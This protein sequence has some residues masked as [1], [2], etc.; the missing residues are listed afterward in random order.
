MTVQFL[1]RG[2]TILLTNLKAPLALLVLGSGYSNLAKAATD[3]TGVISSIE[4]KNNDPEKKS[5]GW[6]LGQAGLFVNLEMSNGTIQL[7]VCGFN[8]GASGYSFT[9]D[10]CRYMQANLLTAQATKRKI[11]FRYSFGTCNNP[12]I[13]HLENIIIR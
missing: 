6:G 2:D 8:P 10:P 11:T 4:F 7:P 5:F 12:P 1:I 3:C 13:K 9:G